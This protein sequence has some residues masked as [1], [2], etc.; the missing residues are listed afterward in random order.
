MVVSQAI[1]EQLLV[2]ADNTKLRSVAIEQGMI[3]LLACGAAA[4]Q[5][6]LTTSSEVLRVTR[7]YEQG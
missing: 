3:P 1:K 7:G 2:S 4:V 6:G 5:A